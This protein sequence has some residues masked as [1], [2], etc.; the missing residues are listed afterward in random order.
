MIL[1]HTLWSLGGDRTWLGSKSSDGVV[2]GYGARSLA[3]ASAA[4]T[5]FTI[6]VTPQPAQARGDVVAFRGDYSP[7]TVV[8]KTNERR[9][10]YVMGDGR[11]LRYPVGVG[12]AG[13]QW[14]GV[15]RID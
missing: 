5:L 11:A 4:A 12:R 10:Y 3:A 1:N 6:V 8:I 2:M 15:S 13:Q 7:G 14:S 9:L